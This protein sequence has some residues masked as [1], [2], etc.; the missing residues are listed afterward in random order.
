MAENR[1]LAANPTPFW[2]LFGVYFATDPQR[3][4]RPIKTKWTTRKLHIYSNLSNNPNSEKEFV[5]EAWFRIPL[6]P[7]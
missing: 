2:C 5:P 4:A 7:P 3:I 6:S 1:I